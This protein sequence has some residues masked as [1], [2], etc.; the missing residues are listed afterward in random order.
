MQ[1]PTVKRLSWLSHICCGL[2][3]FLL[4]QRIWALI[5]SFNNNSVPCQSS[6]ARSG[7][8]FRTEFF[9]PLSPI[10]CSYICLCRTDGAARIFT[11]NNL[12]YLFHDKSPVS[13]VTLSHWERESAHGWGTREDRSTK[14]FGH[15][16]VR[17]PFCLPD[18][19]VHYPLRYAPHAN[20]K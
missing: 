7:S 16:Q 20:L 12:F 2:S 10:H 18:R 13:R 9:N 17:T 3:F 15:F 6:D 5:V 4:G 8:G 1:L 19:R 11:K 14:T